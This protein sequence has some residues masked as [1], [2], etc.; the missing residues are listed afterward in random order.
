MIAVNCPLHSGHTARTLD[1]SSRHVKQNLWRHVS[2]I[3]LL[4]MS[5]RHMGHV[6][7]ESGEDRPSRLLDRLLEPFLCGLCLC[8]V[9]GGGVLDPGAI[10]SGVGGQSSTSILELEVFLA[11]SRVTWLS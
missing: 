11:S 6:A 7:S 5:P 4:S 10:C 3:D 8:E 1:H 9:E 2:V